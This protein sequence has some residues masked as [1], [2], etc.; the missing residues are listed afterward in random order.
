MVFIFQ[1]IEW[2]HITHAQNPVY[3]IIRIHTR[4][5]AKFQRIPLRRASSIINDELHVRYARSESMGVYTICAVC[6]CVRAARRNLSPPSVEIE[7]LFQHQAGGRATLKR[8]LN[9]LIQSYPPSPH[10]STTPNLAYNY[11]CF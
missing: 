3:D 9:P 2:C 8:K 10:P 4:A 11:I 1:C 6:W 5:R 7:P